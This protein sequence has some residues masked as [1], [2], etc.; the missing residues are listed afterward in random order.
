MI[1]YIRGRYKKNVP[2]LRSWRSFLSEKKSAER[3][4]YPIFK[5]DNIDFKIKSGQA[6]TAF[7]L[8]SGS[9]INQLNGNNFKTIDE[10]FSIGINH[11]FAHSFEPNILMIESFREACRH[12]DIYNWR[13]ENFFRWA[14][15][16]RSHIL[17]KDCATGNFF[18]D[19]WAGLPEKKTYFVPKMPLHATSNYNLRRKCGWYGKSRFLARQLWFSRAS[20]SLA[21]SLC[22]C[23]GFKKIVLCGID[24]INSRH[25]WDVYVYQSH[26][27]V[28]RPPRVPLD[29]HKTHSTIDYEKSLITA[30]EVVY[31]FSEL[32]FRRCD[33][34]IM[35]AS[36]ESLLYPRIPLYQFSML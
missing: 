2:I 34:E 10:N 3:Y 24:M 26:L 4:G 12:S 32:L 15:A 18:W 29:V 28:E 19:D 20:V 6:S 9:T 30:D 35:V 8:G 36:K 21:I 7:I 22:V 31:A 11:W 17:I 23:L 5:V 14:Y 16:A 1:S 25:F 27:L 33:V 13:A